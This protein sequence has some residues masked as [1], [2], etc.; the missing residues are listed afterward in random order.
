MKKAKKTLIQCLT[1][2]LAATMSLSMAGCSLFEKSESK[3]EQEFISELGGVSETYKGAVSTQSYNTAESAAQAFV[4]E[5]VVGEQKATVVNTTSQGTLSNEQVAALQ[6][7]A[8]VQTG[9]VSVEKMEVEYTTETVARTNTNTQN[10]K[11]TVYV[12][13]Y[14]NDWK[15]YTPAP[16]TGQTISK[17]YYDSVFNYEQ[18]QNCTMTTTMQV[19]MKLLMVIDVQVS[20]TQ[21]VKYADNKILLEQ[22]MSFSGLGEEE[23]EYVGLYIEETNQGSNCFVKNSQEGTWQEANLHQVGFSSVDELMPF[24]DSYLDYTYFTKTDYGFRMNDKNAQQF[25][26]ESLEKEEALK[27]FLQGNALDMDLF[28]K[29]YVSNGVL[30]GMRQDAN[31][32][33]N[34]NIDSEGAVEVDVSLVNTTICTNY[35]TT[36]VNKPQT[37]NVA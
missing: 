23:T 19:D 7:P 32:S 17:S 1:L 29:Y 34:I 25:I 20:M 35:G 10:K 30:S 14:A 28:I 16:I 31:F 12:I 33:L 13:K 3:K 9:I 37:S 4:Q 36:V 24:Y 26:R 21:V 11:V 6:L 5:E 27:E 8:E 15:Y 2:A 18:Y 22:T